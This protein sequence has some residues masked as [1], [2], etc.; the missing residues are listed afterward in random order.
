MDGIIREFIQQRPL[1]STDFRLPTIRNQQVD[2]SSPF[3]GSI[4]NLLVAKDLQ[5]PP[6]FQAASHEQIMSPRSEQMSP[7]S[8]SSW[9]PSTRAATC[10]H[11]RF[12]ARIRRL[13]ARDQR[14]PIPDRLGDQLNPAQLLEHRTRADT[15][16]PLDAAPQQQS[17]HTG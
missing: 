3:A 9:R 2:G 8:V 1:A 13:W 16:R 5:L 15:V 11:R 6:L 7:G 4:T 12:L 10:R 14:F 17:R